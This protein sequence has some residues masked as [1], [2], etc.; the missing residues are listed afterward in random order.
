MRRD[1]TYIPTIDRDRYRYT[2]GINLAVFVTLALGFAELASADP[3]PGFAALLQ[4]AQ[5]SAPRLVESRANVESAQ[6]MA[7]QSAAFPNPVLDVRSENFGGDGPYN[8]FAR[9]ETTVS[10]NQAVEINGKRAARIAA[11]RAD[12]NAVQAVSE[13]LLVDFAYDLAV[14]YA[15]AESAQTTVTIKTED[16]ARTEEDLRAARLLVKAGKEADL[17]ALQAQAAFAGAQAELERA[18][19]DSAAT[20]AHLS[21]LVGVHDTYSAIGPSLLRAA[22]DLKAPSP[23]PPDV[24]PTVL[25]AQADREA[26]VRQ[27]ALER[28]RSFG[29]VTLSFGTRRLAGEDVNALV[30][31]FSVPLPLFDRNRGAIEARG[32]DLVAA[33][34][35][36]NA[37]RLEAQADWNSAVV[38]AAAAQNRVRASGE[39]ESTAR[40][41]YRL[42]RLGYDAGRTPLFELSA[43]RRDL[44]EAQL[45]A[46]D[47]RRARIQAE[48]T[49]A[50]LAGRIPFGDLNQ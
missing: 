10:L 6:G 49:L 35:R 41:A 33:D 23:S 24:F 31:G 50:R 27:L 12:V 30:A 37:A 48:A 44:G 13:Q 7:R 29:D 42:A 34:A 22:S 28:K 40:E 21:T 45:R 1:V 4:Q 18:R 3:A 2:L 11:G 15:E 9:A 25:T 5:S 17:R 19:A 32:A 47:S 26:R 8:R 20:L 36:L 39:A 16:V 46:L 43:S 14:A 38:Q